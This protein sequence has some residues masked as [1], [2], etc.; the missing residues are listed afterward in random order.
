MYFDVYYIYI[1]A[2][3]L[4]RDMKKKLP[5]S[6]KKHHATFLRKKKLFIDI[7]LLIN[8]RNNTFYQ[9]QWEP[10]WEPAENLMGC[11][12]LV[13]EFWMRFHPIALE[14]RIKQVIVCFDWY[15]EVLN[16][17]RTDTLHPIEG[18]LLFV[19]SCAW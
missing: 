19:P 8:Q 5:F 7:S 6:T 14:H 9:V 2:I 15:Q 11:E 17:H 3:I 10:T 13:N 18:S 1:I 16:A 12:N 4:L